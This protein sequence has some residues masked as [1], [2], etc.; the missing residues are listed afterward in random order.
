MLKHMYMY[1][2][3]SKIIAASAEYF[4]NI[5]TSRKSWCHLSILSPAYMDCLNIYKSDTVLA[6]EH[7]T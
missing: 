7:S 3:L 2:R 5:S 1:L 4:F 6:T